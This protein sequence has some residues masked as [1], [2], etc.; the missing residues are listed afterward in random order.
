VNSRVNTIDA[1]MLAHM[2]KANCFLV[3]FGVESGNQ[4]ILDYVNKGITLDQ[5][6]N[7]FKW[8]KDTSIE[9][10][11]HVVFGLAPF[12]TEKTIK[13]TLDFI[14]EI[15]PDYANFHIATPY[16]GT[17]LYEKYDK[18]GYI[19]NKDY[20]RLESPTANITLPHL[21]NNDLEH[22]RDR[23]F[24]DFYVTPGMAFR[25][26]KKVRSA[27]ELVNLVSNGLWFV[28]GWMNA[29]KQ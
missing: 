10:A 18:A 16:P 2:E 28:N 17:E 12:E 27:T 26:L 19:I 14:K 22:W 6:R 24:F 4:E 5:T 15:K 20:A 3:A 23:A 13:K 1:E 7:A 8:I 25:Q 29:R 9:S 11:S 21:S